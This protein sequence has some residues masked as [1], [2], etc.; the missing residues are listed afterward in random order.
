M[1]ASLGQTEYML[2]RFRGI[3][4]NL[5]NQEYVL[6]GIFSLYSDDILSM[7]NHKSNEKEIMMTI[8]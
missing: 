8:F 2:N 4:L 3:N 7:F 5:K 1:E 6:E